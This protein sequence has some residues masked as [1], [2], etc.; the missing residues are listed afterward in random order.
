MSTV[1]IRKAA[2]SIPGGVFPDE[3]K[4][5]S[6]SRPIEKIPLPA[7]LIIAITQP[8]YQNCDIKVA[9][10]DYVLKG[11]LIA[12]GLGSYSLA[13]HASSSGTVTFIEP[14]KVPNSSGI[15]ELCIGIAT[16]GLD[17]WCELNAHPDYQE[18][19]HNEQILALIAKAGIS[20]LGGSGFPTHIK[21]NQPDEIH[22]LIINACECEPFITADDIL[23]RERAGEIIEG[24][25]ILLHILKPER[26]F[27]G[28][29][30]NKQQAIKILMQSCDDERIQFFSVPSQYPSGAEKQLIQI[31]T[32]VEI[33]YNRLAVDVGILCQNVATAYAINRAVIHGEPLVS[34]ITT[35]TGAALEA[36]GNLE[37][38]IGT[39]MAELLDH[40]G[41]QQSNLSNVIMGGSLMGITLPTLDLPVLKTSNCLIATTQNELPAP[42]P[43][44][45]CT[46]CGLCVDACPVKLLPQQLYWFARSKE[47]EKAQAHHLMDCIECGACAYV[48]PS[49]IPLVQYYR[50]TKASIKAE[51]SK[52]TKAG[53]SQQRFEARQL[54]LEQE[55]LAADKRRKQR[56]SLAKQ[57]SAQGGQAQGAIQAALARVKAKKAAQ[58]KS[59]V[60]T[61]SQSG[62]SQSQSQPGQSQKISDE[63]TTDEN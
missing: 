23:M 24:I 11:Q 18:T 12:Q 39:P 6:L 21:L 14:R 56:A 17:K 54:R 22:T 45:A 34:R 48:C 1:S 52:H 10:G 37:V 25:K 3:N 2:W 8:A 41:L 27:V 44:Q 38:L 35:V 51:I 55:K 28:I 30:D 19:L 29:E 50:A 60:Q 26:C 4:T 57:K 46:R 42:P 36:P 32:G 20:G 62:Q 63:S 53:Q 16:D 5:Q 47:H 49:H 59:S 31:L 15:D 40:A 33:P 9:I 58:A 7:H 61:E 43:A 13:Y